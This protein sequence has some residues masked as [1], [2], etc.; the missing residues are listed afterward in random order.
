MGVKGAGE[1]RG[2]S[3]TAPTNAPTLP[4]FFKITNYMHYY[5]RIKKQ[6]LNG[7]VRAIKRATEATLA[8]VGASS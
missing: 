4:L 6:P 3:R 1:S 5:C 2:G 8:A 7:H